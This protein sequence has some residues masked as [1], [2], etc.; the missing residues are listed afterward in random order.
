MLQ[1]RIFSTQNVY[2]GCLYDIF[3]CVTGVDNPGHPY[4]MT[5]GL[6]A[7]DEESYE[8][9]AELFDPVIDGRHNGYSKVGFSNF[10]FDMIVF[11]HLIIT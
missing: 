6:V 4:I 3:G 11:D 2:Y 1:W 7:G 5:V 9:F 8:D 10:S